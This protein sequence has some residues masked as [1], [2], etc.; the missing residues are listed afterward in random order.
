MGQCL[1]TTPIDQ[2]KI[3]D[4]TNA[5]DVSRPTFYRLYAD[6]YE[7]VKDFYAD[8]IF[9]L[10]EN[11]ETPADMNAATKK[12]LEYFREN[13]NVTRNMFFS[14]DAFALKAFL[15]NAFYESNARFWGALGAD[16][17][18]EGVRK[19]LWLYSYGTVSFLMEWIKEG[20]PGD[21][22]ALS[23]AFS[24]SVPVGPVQSAGMDLPLKI[25]P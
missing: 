15:R 5:A 9:A 20:M 14:K 2:I 18:D 1:E 24:L 23:D 22:Q 17:D 19:S 4:L 25:R 10:Y 8:A 21:L 11:V 13:D 6:K 16:L 7:L 3:S 12:T